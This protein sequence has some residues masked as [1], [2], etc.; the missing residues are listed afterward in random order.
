MRTVLEKVGFREFGAYPKAPVR[1]QTGFRSA[2]DLIEFHEEEDAHL[3]QLTAW[4]RTRRESPLIG[5]ARIAVQRKK[6]ARQF[7]IK[8]GRDLSAFSYEAR[9]HI[10]DFVAGPGAY[11]QKVVVSGLRTT[12]KHSADVADGFFLK[13]PGALMVPV[14]AYGYYALSPKFDGG[15]PIDQFIETAWS[16]VTNGFGH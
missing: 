6:S 8:A 4:K 13:S 2:A 3:E 14:L 16:L 1:P 11:S 9:E 5:L 7:L 12:A 15:N 10:D